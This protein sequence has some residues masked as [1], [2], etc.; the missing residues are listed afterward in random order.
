MGV[1]RPKYKQ[2]VTL[3]KQQNTS[4]SVTGTTDETTLFTA[5]LPGGL[6]G[7]NGVLCVDQLHSWTSNANNKNFRLYLGSTVFAWIV[8][9]TGAVSGWQR[10]IFNRNNQASQVTTALAASGWEVPGGVVITG[11]EDT[12]ADLTFKLTGQLANAADT[13]VL[14]A[15]YSYLVRP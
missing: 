8:R 7:P 2:G 1:W 11:T 10:F 14:E 9:T 4:V 6:L 5:T 3:W 15:F 12:S 13:L